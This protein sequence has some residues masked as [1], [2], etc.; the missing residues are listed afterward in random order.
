MATDGAFA[1][2]ADPKDF[3]VWPSMTTATQP[4]SL[5]RIDLVRNLSKRGSRIAKVAIA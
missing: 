3:N 2:L 4:T 5:Y 1:V